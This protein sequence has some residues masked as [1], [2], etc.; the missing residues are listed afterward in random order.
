MAV[1]VSCV[2]DAPVA[3]NDTATVAEDSGATAASTCSANDTDVDGGPK[4]IASATEPA[5]GSVVVAG[6]GTALTY[7]PDA[8]Y[9]NDPVHGPPTTSPTDPERRLR[10]R[11]CR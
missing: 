6:D 7:Q 11:P 1:T 2:D 5:H 3:V 9:C 4:T 10:A 8:D